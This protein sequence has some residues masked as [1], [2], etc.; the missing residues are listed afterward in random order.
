LLA[1]TL[2][3]NAHTKNPA[4]AKAFMAY[5]AEPANTNL[6]AAGFNALPA[7]PNCQYT[8]PDYLKPFAPLIQSGRF[9]QLPTWPNAKVQSDL[10]Q[11]I[12]SVFIGHST[13]DSVLKQMQQDLNP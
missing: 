13:P 7:I 12:Q 3:V 1:Y 5:L 6:L 8:P 10:N 11:G 4:T 2:A 9:G